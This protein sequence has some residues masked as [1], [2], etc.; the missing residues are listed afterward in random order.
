MHKMDMHMSGLSRRGPNGPHGIEV[1]TLL[2]ESQ[3]QD[4]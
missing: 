4:R 2:A 1:L 3:G